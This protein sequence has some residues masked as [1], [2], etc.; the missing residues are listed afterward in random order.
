MLLVHRN[1]RDIDELAAPG[2][3]SDLGRG[4]RPRPRREDDRRGARGRRSRPQGRARPARRPHDRRRRRAGDDLARRALDAWQRK[5]KQWMRALADATALRHHRFGDVAFLLEPELKEGRGGL[6]DVHGLRAVELAIPTLPAARA[7][8]SSTRRRRCSTCASRCTAPPRRAPTASCS[9][10][11]TA[12][13]DALGLPDADALMQQVSSAARTIGWTS[14]DK[15]R[16]VESYL[17]G[18]S[19]RV[20]KRDRLD[21]RRRGAARR[22]DRHAGRRAD[23]RRVAAGPRRG[24][25]GRK[26]ARRSPG[27]ARTP[28]R[29][30]GRAGRSVAR[31]GTRRA[32]RAARHRRTTRSPR[33][34]RSTSTA[35]SSACCRSGSRCAA[36][37]S[38]TRT[39]A[40][41][42]TG[43]CSRPRRRPPRS[44]TGCSR[45]DLLAHRRLAAR[46]RQGLPGRSHR[47]RHRADGTDRA[48]HGLLGG[49]TSTCSSG[50]SATT[51]CS[52][53][54]RPAATSA[55][56]RPSQPGRRRGRRPADAR[57]ARRAHRSRLEGH[58]RDRVVELEGDAARASSSTGSPTC[59]KARSRRP[60]PPSSNRGSQALVD[61]A[62][63]RMLIKGDHDH[64]VVVAPDRPGL[65]CHLAGV[66]ALQGLDVLAADVQSSNGSV[67]VDEFR[68]QPT[69]GDAPDWTRF[70]DNVVKVL[71]G[72]LA[73]EARLAERAR[74]YNTRLGGGAASRVHAAG[75]A[76]QR[77]VRR[78]V[79][80]GGPR[81]ERGRRAL[82]DHSRVL[83][84]AP[85]HPPRQG[86]DA[87]RRGGRQLLRRRPAR[88]EARRATSASPSSDAPCS[89]SCPASTPERRSPRLE[90][91]AQRRPPTAPSSEQHAEHRARA[92]AIPAD[93][94]QRGD[95]DSRRRRARVRAPRE[96]APS[97]TRTSRSRAISSREPANHVANQP[98][99][100]DHEE[101]RAPTCA[102]TARARRTAPRPRR[103]GSSSPTRSR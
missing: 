70:R 93:E 95:G 81:R 19:G 4:H 60:R 77:R 7:A 54:R 33:S 56:R 99:T 23:G 51:C 41:P 80:R 5:H 21:E 18:P 40:S 84:P 34:R 101:D 9:S 17:K 85:R 96:P 24:R 66:L 72:R 86:A 52:P 97:A 46:S 31:R 29:R 8:R 39:T 94:R 65:F 30:G 75:D 22:R 61:E 38:T 53:T 14:D 45:P 73:L 16:R 62:D 82:P 32:R 59:S 43:T 48:A 89:S 102:A 49:P 37:R 79:G 100:D 10:N 25:V 74:T 90:R 13:A 87:R 83:R 11:S 28:P 35:S 36:A 57:A 91:A 98:S 63:G 47:G 92:R 58:R 44:P 71:D 64:V 78:R 3:V 1:R 69:H 68:V 50:S 6:R 26:P 88:R 103:A 20:A 76:A 67:A 42:S 55:I 27:D 12:V 2:L 15:W